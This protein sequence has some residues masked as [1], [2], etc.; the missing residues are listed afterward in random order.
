MYKGE[1]FLLAFIDK[2][3][4]VKVIVGDPL[5]GYIDGIGR[6]MNPSIMYNRKEF[7]IRPQGFNN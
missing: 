5:V 6:C 3:Y 7:L 4:K 1:G 2:S